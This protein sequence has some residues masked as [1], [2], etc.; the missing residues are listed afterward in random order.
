LRALLITYQ[1]GQPRPIKTVFGRDLFD[2][3]QKHPDPPV[4]SQKTGET[5]PQRGTHLSKRTQ[6]A[7]R[8]GSLTGK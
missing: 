5:T 2:H 3:G 8:S 7:K 6:Q 1:R 4:F